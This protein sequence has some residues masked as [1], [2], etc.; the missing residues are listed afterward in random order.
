MGCVFERIH[1]SGTTARPTEP[2]QTEMLCEGDL[3]RVKTYVWDSSEGVE[4]RVPWSAADGPGSG[5]L[6][7]F[8]N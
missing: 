2:N 4:T 1:F 3:I 5:S 6:G 7:C 8:P